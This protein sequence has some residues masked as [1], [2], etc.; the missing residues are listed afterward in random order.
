MCMH[1]VFSTAY[2]EKGGHVMKEKG[3]KKRETV[4]QASTAVWSMA[5]DGVVGAGMD[6]GGGPWH[7]KK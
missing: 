2:E 5:W 3:P 7:G 1:S 6:G 4:F